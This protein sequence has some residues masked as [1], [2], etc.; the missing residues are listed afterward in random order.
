MKQLLVVVETDEKTKQ[1]VAASFPPTDIS[2]SNHRKTERWTSSVIEG[3]TSESRANG[4]NKSG[5][6]A[7]QLSPYMATEEEKKN[8]QDTSMDDSGQ[9]AVAEVVS[10]NRRTQNSPRRIVE[11]LT[12]RESCEC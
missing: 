12:H 8:I 7:I 3:E 10:S 9:A 11:Q 2:S 6:M 5:D 4:G 1:L